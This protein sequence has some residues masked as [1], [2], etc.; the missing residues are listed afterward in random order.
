MFNLRLDI[1]FSATLANTT[2]LACVWAAGVLR[3]SGWPGASLGP[4]LVWCQE[5]AVL[6]SAVKDIALLAILRDRAAAPWARMVWW[7][8]IFESALKGVGMAYAAVAGISWLARGFGGDGKR[9][10][11]G[12]EAARMRRDVTPRRSSTARGAVRSVDEA[13]LG[14]GVRVVGLRE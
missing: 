13:R 4:V 2:G 12:R 14:E 3:T 6:I 5:L 9:A 7:C 10:E 1:P 11:V 8:A